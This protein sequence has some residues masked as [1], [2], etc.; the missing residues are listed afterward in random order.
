MSK[1]TIVCP[2]C[3]SAYSINAS[4]LSQ[5]RNFKCHEC[6]HIWREEKLDSN[7]LIYLNPTESNTAR[8]N[9]QQ[10]PAENI[11]STNQAKKGFFK[12]FF[13]KPISWFMIISII[14]NIIFWLLYFLEY[15]KTT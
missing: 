11:S 13:S 2:N 4:L 9:I 14:A 15:Y 10:Q 6:Q 12:N 7:K 5:A 8:Q 3:E 1:T